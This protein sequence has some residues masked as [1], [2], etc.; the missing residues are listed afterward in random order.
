MII[1]RIN[2]PIWSTKKSEKLEGIRLLEAEII[3]WGDWN[4]GGSGR[5]V[6][7]ADNIGAGIGEYV[8]LTFGSAVRDVVFNEESPFKM[9]TTAIV[10]KVYLEN[11]ILDNQSSFFIED[12]GRK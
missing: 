3:P 11:E 1:G 4:L 7:V 9:V 5:Y 12:P 2:R 6:V 8:F 10:D